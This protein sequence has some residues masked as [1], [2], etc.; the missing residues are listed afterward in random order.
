MRNLT[1][2]EHAVPSHPPL[3]PPPGPTRWSTWCLG[4]IIGAV[5][6]TVLAA[7]D[8]RA[9]G[10]WSHQNEL[11]TVDAW[12]YRS[13][14]DYGG[15]RKVAHEITTM[16]VWGVTVFPERMS[17]TQREANVWGLMILLFVA[18]IGATLGGLLGLGIRP[19][20]ARI[21]R[22]TVVRRPLRQLLLWIGEGLTAAGTRLTHACR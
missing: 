4:S 6:L 13:L 20:A 14:P 16:S 1:M 10:K 9:V 7:T 17:M 5:T 3:P 21:A 11:I 19:L 22:S 12:T 15:V 2:S 18:L 8:M